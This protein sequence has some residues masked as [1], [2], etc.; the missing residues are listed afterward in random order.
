MVVKVKWIFPLGVNASVSYGEN[1]ESLVG[2]FHA[3]QY[4][5]FARMK[6]VFN[7]VFNINISEAGVH[8]LLNRFAEKTPDVYQIINGYRPVA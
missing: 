7:H 3:R 2:C 1:I 4:L 8:C 6:E 5:P